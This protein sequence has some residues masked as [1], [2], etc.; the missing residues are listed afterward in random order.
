MRAKRHQGDAGHGRMQNRTVGG[1]RVGGRPGRCRDDD[2]VGAQKVDE[3]AID[4]DFQFYHP[5]NIT[6]VDHHV[7]QGQGVQHATAGAKDFD[8]EQETLFAGEL[9]IEQ[10]R[11][12][13]NHVLAGDVGHEAEPPLIHADQRH[14]VFGKAACGVQHSA[15]ATQDDR[16]VGARTDGRVR[17]NRMTVGANRACRALL[18]QHRH[19]APLQEC[20]Q[21]EQRAGNIRTL[22]LA[23][24]R[25]RAEFL[26][27][28]PN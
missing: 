8:I 7:V 15:V 28:A 20:G 10:R 13:G 19:A 2:A 5:A 11:D 16:Q 26:V 23:D 18:D 22:V 6:L 24:Q 3:L 12:A 9:A 25:R 14:A 27:H 21:G 17:R 4:R 1:K